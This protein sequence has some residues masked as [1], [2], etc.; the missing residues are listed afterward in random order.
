MKIL[1]SDLISYEIPHEIIQDSVILSE[2]YSEQ[3]QD[4][5]DSEQDLQDLD[6]DPGD[7]EQDLQDLSLPIGSRTIH[8]IL[9]FYES[10]YSDIFSEYT[11]DNRKQLENFIIDLDYLCLDVLLRL[12]CEHYGSFFNDMT[13]DE[14]VK[15]FRK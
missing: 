6:Q 10:K 5:G 7:S 14:V 11:I 3:D 15:Y 4:P 2:V 9:L 1:T 8:K 12:A 13:S